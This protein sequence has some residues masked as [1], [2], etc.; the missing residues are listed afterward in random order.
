MSVSASVLPTTAPTVALSWPV[1]QAPAHWQH[2]D[3]I[4]DLHLQADASATFLAWQ[5]YLQSTTA[6]AVFILGDLFDV[7]VGDDAMSTH[8]SPNFEAACAQILQTA[9]Q[10]LAVYLMH[11]NRDFLLG[12]SFAK[13][14]GLS[15]LHD[16]SLL[17]FNGQRW[18]L[19]HGDAL[20]LA[21]TD[22]LQFRA[23]VRS[24]IWQHDFLAQ[25]LEQRQQIARDLRQQS[26]AH[27]HA[28]A[29]FID[30]D[31]QASCDWLRA[32]QAQT[33]IHGHTHR[34]AEHDLGAGLRRIVLSDWDALATP[35]RLEVLRLSTTSSDPTQACT[36][37]RLSVAPAKS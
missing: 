27:K 32:A 33:L 5:R 21:D 14:A 26:E 8:P 28:N 34:P 35:P 29:A 16:P 31:P 17:E 36:I 25:S 13:A 19:S 30:L 18:L 37:Q 23:Q 22:Y 15:L 20:F 4:S 6:N 2:I 10:G 12:A 9:A 3:F 11:G 24:S 1:L 7:W